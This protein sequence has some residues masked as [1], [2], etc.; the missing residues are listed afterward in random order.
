MENHRRTWG[1]FWTYALVG[2]IFLGF[3]SVTWYLV[4]KRRDSDAAAFYKVSKANEEQI[5]SVR[6]QVETMPDGYQKETLLKLLSGVN[7]VR[8]RAEI[9]SIRRSPGDSTTTVKGL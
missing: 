4:E 9:D 5:W 7:I 2:L 3:Y 8:T 6:R 1:K